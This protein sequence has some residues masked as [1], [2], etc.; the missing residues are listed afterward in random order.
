[1]S[2][3]THTVQSRDDH[4]TTL[5]CDDA[6]SGPAHPETSAVDTAPTPEK[7]DEQQPKP[8]YPT[9]EAWVTEHFLPMY[10]RTLGGEY[11]WCAQ[12]WLHAEAI[13]RLTALWYAWESMRLQGA[14]G[15]GL[16][17]RDHLDHQLPVL[18]GARGPFYQCTEQ[19]HLEPHQAITQP[20]PPDWWA[21]SSP[22]IDQP[23]ELAEFTDLEP[24]GGQQVDEPDVSRLS[25]A[26]GET[27][28]P[29][30]VKR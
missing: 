12:W 4:P 30:E 25:A 15:I 19:Q 28:E 8:C 23:T 10:R 18:L 5:T 24:A 22:A 2:N 1:M 6:A 17:Y 26:S 27:A 13:S 21:S 11:R 16:W 9:V 3:E 20:V 7:V 14:S 29:G